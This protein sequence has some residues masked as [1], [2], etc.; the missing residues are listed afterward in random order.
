MNCDDIDNL[1]DEFADGTL[2]PDERLRFEQH[3]AGCADCSR[4]LRREAQLRELLEDYGESV[5]AMPDAEYFAQALASAARQGARQQRNRWLMTGFA[6]AV[7]ASLATVVVTALLLQAPAVPRGGADMS[8][9][10]MTLAEPRVVNLVFSA[11][12]RLDDATLTLTLP[13]GV[14]LAGF[15]GRRQIRWQ[16]SL[17]RGRNLLPLTLVAATATDGELQAVLQHGDEQRTFRVRLAAQQ[18]KAG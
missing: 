11:A 14:E 1:L 4:T 18:E 2:A 5:V 8:T 6:A 12:T 10:T 7:A 15:P 3:V 17:Q 13:A 16:T 9:V